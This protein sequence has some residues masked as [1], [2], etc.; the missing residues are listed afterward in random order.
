M[1]SFYLQCVCNLDYLKLENNN[2][3][4][5]IKDNLIGVRF[6]CLIFDIDGVLIDVKRSYNEAIK[7]T[8]CFILKQFKEKNKF[9]KIVTHDIILKFRKSGGFNNDIDTSYA[10]LVTLLSLPENTNSLNAKK[11]LY[12]VANNADKRG[13]E[14]VEEFLLKYYS[15]D[16]IIL[17]RL[18][19]LL[20]ILNYPSSNKNIHD[21]IIS[22]IFDE[23]FYGFELFKKR[24][25]YSAK[26]Y[27]GKPLIDNDKIIIKQ[28]I[29][30]I[31]FNKF[32]KNIGIISGRSRIA[33]VYS[34]GEKISMFNEKA[35]IFLED[36]N[37]IHAKPSTYGIKKVIDNIINQKNKNNNQKINLIYFGDSM[38]DL[39]MVNMYNNKISVEKN[40]RK[41]WV[42]FCGIY[43]S[44]PNPE[45]LIHR[46]IEKKAD[47]IIKSVNDVPYIL[48]KVS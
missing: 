36:E 28:N 17:S 19:K 5:F 40:E 21:N 29:S 30:N 27:F 24:Y 22:R 47:I 32:Q 6:D 42:Y 3:Q 10:I 48:N 38:E 2:I 1:I 26:Y 45:E 37:R 7:K 33:A 46:F 12:I 31:L 16:K 13:I 25:G 15:Q 34:L 23:Y 43:G 8:V 44:S 20:K 18:E 39:L 4:Y 11:F 14:S 35:C 9:N 41:I